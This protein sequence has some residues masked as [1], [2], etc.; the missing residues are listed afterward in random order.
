M[1]I[2][3]NESRAVRTSVILLAVVAILFFLI[4]W[5]A[6]SQEQSSQRI[7]SDNALVTREGNWSSQAA[8]AASD[9]TYLYS[10]GAEGDVLE[11]E[12]VGTTLEVIYI[13][14]PALGTLALEV[15]GTVLR[16]VIT[17]ADQTAYGQSTIINY[18]SNEP[19]MLRVY[20]QEGGIVA[21]DAFVISIEDATDSTTSGAPDEEGGIF[22]STCTPV[23][24]IH[25]VSLNYQNEQVS[26]AF[27]NSDSALSE[28]G[29][30]VAFES[31]SSEL[32][33]GDTNGLIDIFVY[34]RQTCQISRVSVANDGTEA[35]LSSANPDISADGR[36]VVFET[37]AE[38]VSADSNGVS[39]IYMYDQETF[40][41]TRI[42][43][44]NLAFPQANG[45]S[46]NP[47]ISGDGTR[48][49]FESTATN[50]VTGDTNGESD[51]FLRDLTA[52]TTTRVS[53][54]NAGNEATGGGS[55]MPDIASA[56]DHVAFESEATNL[57]ANDNNGERDIFARALTAGTTIRVSIPSGGGQAN[58]NSWDPAISSNGTIIAFE[59]D[60]TNMVAGDT[61]NFRDVFVRTTSGTPTTSL[62]S[63]STAGVLGALPSANPAI[64]NGGR[65]IVFES[66]SPLATE[67]TNGWTDIYVRDRVANTTT[68][69]SIARDGTLGDDNT[70]YPAISGNGNYVSFESEATN[71]IAGDTND[72]PD[73]YVAPRFPTPADNLAVFSP[74]FQIV[75]LVDGLGDP[76]A[77][78]DYTF[79]SAYAPTTGGQWVM[80]DWDSDGLETPG[81]YSNGAFFFTN[82]PGETEDWELL[83]IGVTGS[84][85][86]GRLDAAI[87]N[88][89]IGVVEG[90]DFPPYGMAFVLY[91]TC[92]LSGNLLPTIG[93][94]WLSVLLP[95]SAGFIGTHQFSAGDF[96]GDGVATIA[97]RRGTSITWT[98]DAATTGA[99]GFP[100][101]Q[102]IGAPGISDEGS[103]VAGDWD[104]DTI[105]SFGLY[106]QDGE[107]YYRH[108]LDFNSG[109]YFNQS[110]GV[111]LA[112]V[113]QVSAW[114]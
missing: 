24:A 35:T 96:D 100:L 65:Q 94:Q 32:V 40:E 43:R 27:T 73:I 58:G 106:Y 105:A 23:N 39:D 111:P 104:G 46:H 74:N 98:N 45:A 72:D 92:D 36:Y 19:H 55:F 99:G 112:G 2:A 28:D 29:R 107:F 113:T 25:R 30:F 31:A 64:A 75:G 6:H 110:L 70:S 48:I 3:T 14:G 8:A 101:G 12:F 103:F 67:D 16:T 102:Y 1:R 5:P 15:D 18:L 63:V 91:Y 78:D 52:G 34:D 68:L 86:T 17:R 47:T 76:P 26:G 77:A 97:C 84:P 87:T 9:G 95:D 59:S 38:L 79:Y 80:G 11:L 71:L 93:F 114:R 60:A 85:V 66:D 41:I 7:E 81:V 57:V 109:V 42:S 62:V 33:A 53:L 37:N 54:T 10:S 50:L 21:V 13:A 22:A 49:A 83:W 61:N 4:G 89:C 90:A 56:G 51:I 44:A 88:D 20:A 108:D 82:E 69:V